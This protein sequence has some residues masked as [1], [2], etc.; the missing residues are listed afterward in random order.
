MNRETLRIILLHE[1][2]WNNVQ[3]KGALAHVQM[4]VCMQVQG[5]GV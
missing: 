3:A 1:E 4:T 2:I 5:L